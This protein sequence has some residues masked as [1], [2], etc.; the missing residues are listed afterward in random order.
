MFP[1]VVINATSLFFH[2]RSFETPA[3][4][5]N[6]TNQIEEWAQG[7]PPPPFKKQRTSVTGSS[8]SVSSKANPNLIKT[9]AP[10]STTTTTKSSTSC[11][12]VVNSTTEVLK[13]K[14]APGSKRL[15][16]ELES[17]IDTNDDLEVEDAASNLYEGLGEDED[18]TLE[19]ADAASSPV[20]ARVAAQVSKVSPYQIFKFAKVSLLISILLSQKSLNIRRGVVAPVREK[21]ASKRRSNQQ[22]P[23]GALENGKWAA[24]FV[25]TFL[26]YV[27]CTQKDV[28]T[29]KSQETITAL[30]GIWNEVYKGNIQHYQKK[31]KHLVEPGGAVHCVVCISVML[32]LSISTNYSQSIQRVIEWRSS[33]GSTGLTVVGDFLTS[34]HL[35]TCEEQQDAAEYLLDHNRYMYLKTR[36]PTEDGGL[37]RK[38]TIHLPAYPLKAIQVKRSGRYR[39]PLVIQTVAQCWIDFEGAVEVPGFVD[40]D[41]FPYTALVLSA[42][43]VGFSLHM[44]LN[45]LMIYR[46]IVRSGYGPKD[47]LP[48]RAT[49]TPG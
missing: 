24:T 38:A 18:D 7:L 9:A 44:E 48:R 13:K 14:P 2:N 12:I 23:S 19:Q 16:E 15:A 43:S 45:I 46:C 3:T 10:P 28:W 11:A 47:I 8:R 21:K 39:G 49:S 17:D 35:E 34:S 5:K 40:C 29:L 26:Q 6:I 32:L 41:Q 30:Q 37:V 42:T 33:I 25:P 20:K 27:G 36:D 4:K 22:L 31:I 1:H